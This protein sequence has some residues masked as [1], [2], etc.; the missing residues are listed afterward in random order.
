[1]GHDVTVL[2]PGRSA[3]PHRLDC[4]LSRGLYALAK[5]V[6][7]YD[8]VIIQFHP[9]TFYRL[10]LTPA[11]RR[12]VTLGFLVVAALSREL[13]FRVHEFDIAGAHGTTLDARLTRAMWR[14]VDRLTLHTATERG[15]LAAAFELP[16]ARIAVREHR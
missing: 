13:E 12:R 2:A 1:A 16:A 8:R 6:S 11:E 7:A 15:G 10:P 9:A 14:A 4:H 5:R 3:E